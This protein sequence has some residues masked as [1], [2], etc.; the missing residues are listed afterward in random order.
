MFAQGVEP[1]AFD[2]QIGLVVTVQFAAP[3][4]LANVDPV[5]SLVAG[6][7]KALGIDEGFQQNGSV[8]VAVLPVLGE[9]AGGHGEH[10]RGQVL[11]LD[12]GKDEKARV[13]DD[14]LKVSPLS[15]KDASR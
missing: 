6:A 8:G 9:L 1:D 12:P 3:L 10:F 15:P 13:V 5:G 4:G 11:R 14:Q 7:C 2:G